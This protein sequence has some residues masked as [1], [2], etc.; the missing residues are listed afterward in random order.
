MLIPEPIPDFSTGTTAI[1]AWPMPGLVMPMPMP[2]TRKPASS[3]VQLRV[4]RDAVHQQQADPDHGEPG[5][6]QDADRDPVRERAG[7]RRDDEAE[8]GQRQ[9]A[10][11]RLQRRVVEHALHVDGQVEEHREHPGREPEGDGGDAVEGGFAE[12]GEVE[13][14]VVAAALDRDEG[15]QQRRRRRSGRRG[16]AGCPSPRGC[17]GSARRSAGRGRARR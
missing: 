17:R 1:A 2:A 12:Q 11:A 8:H 9:E 13:H 3:V 4:G 6:E 14:R 7:D 16:S 10:Q 15:R 5:A